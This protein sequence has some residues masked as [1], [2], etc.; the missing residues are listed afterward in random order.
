MGLLIA[1]GQRETRRLSGGAFGLIAST[2]VEIVMS[3]LLA[4]IMMLIQSGSVMQILLGRDTGWNPQRRDDGS[5]PLRDIVRR[6]R[7]HVAL[8]S[9]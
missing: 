4:P 6:H 5:I 3:S 8:G 1:L 2:L 9:S 7:S